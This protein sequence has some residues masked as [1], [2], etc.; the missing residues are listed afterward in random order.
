[1]P[2][3]SNVVVLMDPKAIAHF[4][5]GGEV[6]MREIIITMGFQCFDAYTDHLSYE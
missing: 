1:M 6:R 3:G 5:S 4:F 2:L